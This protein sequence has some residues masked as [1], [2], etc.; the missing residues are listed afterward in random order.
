MKLLKKLDFMTKYDIKK[1]LMTSFAT[2]LVLTFLLGIMS[3][4]GINYTKG[5]M[6]QFTEG[7]YVNDLAVK[8]IRINAST[9][10]MALREMILNHDT[11]YY[12]NYKSEIKNSME[13]LN[14]YLLQLQENSHTDDE[15]VAE[16]TEK[17]KNW[18]TLAN[19]ILKELENGNR[20]LAKDMLVGNCSRL[21]KEVT[22][23]STE[24]DKRTDMQTEQ[25]LDSTFRTSL[26]VSILVLSI[27]VMTTLISMVIV[28]RLTGSIVNPLQELE[29]ASLEMSKGNLDVNIEYKGN[30]AIARLADSMR[31]SMDT[32]RTYITD[33]DKIMGEISSGNL[34]LKIDKKYI[35]DFANIKTSINK[36]IS[37]TSAVLSQIRLIADDFVDMSSNVASNSESLAE[38]SSE[39][40]GI[41]QE[42]IAQTDMLSQIISDNVNQ[43][44]ESSEMI[45]LA[46]S[47]SEQ[48]KVVMQEMIQAM[49]NIS[50]ASNNIS[51]ITEMID[52]IA[53]QTNLLALNASIEAARAGESGRGFSVVAQEIR[54][55]ANRSV[56]AVKEIES[57]IKNSNTHIS[58]GQEKIVSVS[59]ELNEINEYVSKT[60]DMMRTLLSNAEFEKATVAELTSG[61]N[62]I[63]TVVDRNV[64]SAREGAK[65]GKVLDEKSDELKEMVRYFNI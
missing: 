23:T 18:E 59:N 51:D 39:Q 10:G 13:D 1:R 11:R 52:A 30:D 48:G 34:S 14:N 19:S 41:I 47:K 33:I 16:L 64:E 29:Q 46:K 37:D 62:Q 22:K 35:G 65:S 5:K 42:F 43:V 4:S 2:T 63:A 15:L 50:V 20:E 60:D 9:A 31:S 55:L 12:V 17:V 61:T 53:Q 58:I 45:N 21:L 26:Y 57:M 44:N 32:I 6:T 7:A 38:S 27:L 3:V 56:D 36:S 28:K 49:E 54:D 25:I 24:L 40:A 8:M